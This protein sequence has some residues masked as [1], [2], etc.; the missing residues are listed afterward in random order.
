GDEVRREPMTRAFGFGRGVGVL[1]RSHTTQTRT[2]VRAPAMLG[3]LRHL[4]TESGIRDRHHAGGDAELK[5][6]I[7]ML[8]LALIEPLGGVPAFDLAR[9]LRREIGGVEQ[10][11]RRSTALTSE[12]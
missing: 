3:A 8:E 4:R 6:P 9:E 11:R 12:Q 2:D 5:E 1:D 10:S 7:E